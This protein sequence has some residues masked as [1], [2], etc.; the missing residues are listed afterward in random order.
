MINIK[1]VSGFYPRRKH[2]NLSK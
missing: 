2:E 1:I